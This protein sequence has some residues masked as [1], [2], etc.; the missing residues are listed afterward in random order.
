[1][2]SRIFKVIVF[3]MG[4]GL[5][6]VL[7][8]PLMEDPDHFLNPDPNCPICHAVWTRV[9]V[10]NARIMVLPLP[11]FFCSINLVEHFNYF[12]PDRISIF[13]RGPPATV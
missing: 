13:I 4:L 3:L 1:M 8:G 10:N 12:P 5:F 6:L 2:K 9:S 11:I 7:A